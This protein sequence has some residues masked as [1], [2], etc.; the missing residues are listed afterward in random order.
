MPSRLTACGLLEADAD[1]IIVDANP[2]ILEW[3]GA[4][5]DDIV[6]QPLESVLAIRLHLVKDGGIPADATLR[7]RS[8]AGLPVVV[9]RLP[10]EDPDAPDRVVVFDLSP[11]SEFGRTFRA[12]GSRTERGLKRLQILLSAAVG[13][14]EVRTVEQASELLVDVARRAFAASHATVHLRTGDHVERVAGENPL[15]DHWPPGYKPTGATTLEWNQVLVVPNAEAA[16]QFVPDVPMDEVFRAAG[17]HAAIASPLRYTGE[18]IGSMVCYFDHPR[19]FDDEAVPLAEALANQAAQA[20]ARVRL[21]ETLRRAAMHDEVT[22]LPGRRLVEEEVGRSLS[23]GT[24]RLCVVFIDLDGFKG[25]NDRLGHAAG[26]GLLGEVG[27]R[28]QSIV[29]DRDIVGRFGGDEFIAVG[30]VEHEDDAVS[31]AERIRRSVA[32]P[33]PGIP[34]DL[35]IT[36][37]IG[38]VSAP[39][40]GGHEVVFDQLVRSAD[41][42]MYEAKSAGGDRVSVGRFAG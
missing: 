4:A 32:E 17:I 28:L 9:G 16:N 19:D 15:A 11:D 13:F 2:T 23:S 31:L 42:A 39:E 37:S 10:S 29:R 1:G 41:H 7:L 33:Y 18:S 3:I 40:A 6:G 22:G 14:A 21:E 8:G 34:S 27:R 5:R 38:V 12:A 24:G 36:A 30:E 25:V 20:I 35:P 26:D